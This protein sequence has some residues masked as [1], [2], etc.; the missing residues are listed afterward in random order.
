MWLSMG[1]TALNNIDRLRMIVLADDAL[2]AQLGQ[3]DD[4]AAFIESA[5][6][7]AE[8]RSVMLSR[9]ELEEELRPNPLGWRAPSRAAAVTSSPPRGWLPAGIF[10]RD[11]Q[12]WV[13]W[14]YFGA[15]RLREPFFEESL[16]RALHRPFNMV[17]QL[18]SP[19]E[20]WLE[21]LEAPGSLT[22][23]GLIFH[24][25]RC[26][27]TLTAQMLAACDST[28]VL[29]EAAP[30][31][32]IVRLNP[33]RH[34]PGQAQ[35]DLLNRM[36]MAFGQVRSGDETRYLIKLDSWHT[37]ALPLFRQAFPGVPWVFLYREPEE[38]MVS[39]MWRR[40]MQMAPELVAPSLFGLE[41]PDAP[42]EDYWAQI[43]GAVCEA[44]LH[45]YREG[46]GLLVN[47][48]ELPEAVFTKILPHFG[49]AC[50]EKDR[51]IMAET[52]RFDAKAPDTAFLSDGEAK[53]VAVTG[54]IRLA[55]QRHLNDVY[56]RLEN[57][58]FKAGSTAPSVMG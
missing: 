18:A 15:Q 33:W 28:I 37:L 12:A 53:R 56:R 3:I 46:Q 14:V 16:R 54:P 19:L 26:G 4:R 23:R 21:A 47:Y 22:P 20:A 58:R 13:D 49:V 51:Q 24:M 1:G 39:Q 6:T 38:V 32:A 55:C 36:A 17:F 2:Q 30:I 57:A 31:D 40:G 25:S 9:P 8:A 52:A 35:S 11:D 43:L 7:A 41:P 29:S 27:S 10:W 44:A 42:T 45:H 50:S 48:N 34:A 5:L